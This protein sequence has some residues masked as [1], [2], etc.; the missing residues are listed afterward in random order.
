MAWPF[1]PAETLALVL[2]T[3]AGARWLIPYTLDRRDARLKAAAEKASAIEKD[4]AEK[5]VTAQRET[6]AN[7]DREIAGWKERYEQEH[8]E[9]R[10]D[11][12]R[13]EERISRLESLLFNGERTR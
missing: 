13:Y 12:V 3:G 7:K 1:S 10:E 5:A 4:A 11:E 2:A 9:R 8:R 6:M